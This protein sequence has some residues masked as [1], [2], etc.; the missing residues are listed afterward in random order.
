MPLAD[1]TESVRQKSMA[2]GGI[3]QKTGNSASILTLSDGGSWQ[4]IRAWLHLTF[5]LTDSMLITT[6]DQ[7]SKHD[8]T[9]WTPSIHPQR[10]TSSTRP[11]NLVRARAPAAKSGDPD[12]GDAT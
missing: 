11:G 9:R 3:R 1:D 10:A 7:T 6:I 5:R 12:K 8:R 4:P 2:L